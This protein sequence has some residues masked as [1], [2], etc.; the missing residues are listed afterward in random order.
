MPLISTKECVCLSQASTWIYNAI[1][2]SLYCDQW[3]KGQRWL[4][5]WYWCNCWPSC[6]KLS[7]HNQISH[8]IVECKKNDWINILM[9]CK[10]QHWKLEGIRYLQMSKFWQVVECARLDW[11]NLIIIQTTTKYKIRTKYN[12]NVRPNNQRESRNTTFV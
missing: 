2:P 12:D 4:F 11:C 1:C 5:C 7:F 3:F 9:C 8:R 6:L 10:L